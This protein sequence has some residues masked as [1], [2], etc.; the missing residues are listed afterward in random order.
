MEDK[1]EEL[2][3]AENKLRR[4]EEVGAQSFQG[5]NAETEYG[6]RAFQLQYSP[7]EDLKEMSP[8]WKST[9]WDLTKPK[10]LLHPGAHTHIHFNI[11]LRG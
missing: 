2:V 8:E 9:E 7:L 3:A 5:G 10:K 6:R 1:E 4:R 11:C